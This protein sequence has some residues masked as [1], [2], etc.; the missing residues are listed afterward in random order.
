MGAG[1]GQGEGD[2]TQVEMEEA[3]RGW[4]AQ[5]GALRRVAQGDGEPGDGPQPS[6]EAVLDGQDEGEA[7]DAA[8][9]R[10]R[11]TRPRGGDREM[12]APNTT[13]HESS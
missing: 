10:W 7:V 6:G 8:G 1:E 4:A 11:Q 5:H 2:G 13:H 9:Q 12:R 3:P